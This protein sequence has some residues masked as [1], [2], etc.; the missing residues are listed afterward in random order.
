M[1]FFHPTWLAN[2]PPYLFMK[3]S[4][5]NH[6]TRLFGPTRLIGT[7]EYA[8]ANLFNIVRACVN[9]ICQTVITKDPTKAGML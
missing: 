6:P 1:H 2:F 4:Q 5:N 8:K 9:L 7:W 3:F